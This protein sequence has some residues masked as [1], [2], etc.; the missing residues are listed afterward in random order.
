[1]DFVYFSANRKILLVSVSQP[2]PVWVQTE[3]SSITG[4]LVKVWQTHLDYKGAA[5]YIF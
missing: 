1:M 2:F 5:G 3:Q 4:Q